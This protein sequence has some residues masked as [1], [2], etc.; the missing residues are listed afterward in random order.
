M[1]SYL[2]NNITAENYEIII[3]LLNYEMEISDLLM[4]IRLPRNKGRVIVDTALVAGVNK[5]RFM[6]VHADMDGRLDLSD[7]R[8]IDVDVN[9][10]NQANHIIC[11]E[12]ASLDASILS[13]AQKEKIRE[14]LYC[15]N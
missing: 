5:Y 14:G 12:P 4:S 11:E 8:Y 15:S 13:R 3:T 6:E 10:L 2:I 1:D 7:Y 9:V